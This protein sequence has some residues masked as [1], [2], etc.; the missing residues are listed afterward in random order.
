MAVRAA[1]QEE[2]RNTFPFTIVGRCYT[3][4]AHVQLTPGI[5]IHVTR[6]ADNPHD[7]KAH[8]VLAYIEEEWVPIGYVDRQSAAILAALNIKPNTA[9]IEGNCCATV[10]IEPKA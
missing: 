10:G 8:R 7:K 5:Q 6:E 1:K 4:H 2:L 3:N 9:R